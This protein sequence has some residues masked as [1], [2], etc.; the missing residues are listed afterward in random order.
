MSNTFVHDRQ[1]LGTL[2]ALI[3]AR[4]YL[5]DNFCVI[6]GDLFIS[7]TNLGGLFRVFE[8]DECSALILA[9]YT[10][11]PEDSDLIRTDAHWSATGFMK[12][13]HE[14]V[15]ELPIGNAGIF[16]LKKDCI[17]SEVPSRP[18]DIFQDLLPKLLENDARIRVVF[19]QG[20]IR[21]V[22]RVDRLQDETLAEELPITLS[23]KTAIFFDRD[24]VL[25]VP[26]GHISHIQELFLYPYTSELLQA[27]VGEFNFLGLVTNQPVIA[28]GEASCREVEEINSHI[29]TL[30]HLPATTFSVIKYCPHHPDAGFPGEIPHLK[31]Y[32]SCRK[33][34]PGML[35]DALAELRVRAT[36]C[37][38]VGDLESDLQAAEAVG[39]QWIHL[40]DEALL[41]CT[42]SHMHNRGRCMS[43]KDLIS[44]LK[45]GSIS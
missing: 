20:I 4:D 21:D 38:F 44:G 30:S 35:L 43:A 18:Q 22:G 1:R 42:V 12:Y 15:P 40:I 41:P 31:K 16:F 32:C 27:A 14:M 7:E 6:Y 37:I 36:S 13:P 26:N 39:M 8:E 11:H 23:S 33:P 24:G 5:A 19:H 29:L 9:K 10:N 28:R 25:N 3:Q 34:A 17:P 45:N 2:G